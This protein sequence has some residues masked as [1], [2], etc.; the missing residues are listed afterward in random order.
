[1]SNFTLEEMRH[2]AYE[3]LL[4]HAEPDCTPSIVGEEAAIL[5]RH[6]RCGVWA[7]ATEYFYG[8]EVQIYPRNGRRYM[9][10][11]SGTSSASAPEWPRRVSTYHWPGFPGSRLTEAGGVSWED[12]GCDYENVFDVRGAA[13]EAWTIKTARASHL[14][15]TSAGN[16]KI[17]ASALQEQCR[18]RAREFTPLV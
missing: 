1:V 14:V 6:M 18:A 13:H 2:Q 17:D 15:T 7:P 11:C 9:C 5:E 4:L 16:A 3:Q 12:V 10:V 8:D